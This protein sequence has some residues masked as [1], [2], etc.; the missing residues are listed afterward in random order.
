MIKKTDEIF[1]TLGSNEDQ[2]SFNLEVMIFDTDKRHFYIHHDVILPY[3]PLCCKWLNYRNNNDM[4]S[5]LL[6]VGGINESIEIFDIDVMDA[7]EPVCT[8]GGRNKPKDPIKAQKILNKYRMNPDF[9]LHSD[10]SPKLKNT[11]LGELKEGSHSDSIMCLDWHNGNNTNIISGSADNS[12]KI[13]DLNNKSCINTI[14]NHKDKVQDIAIHLI[15]PKVFISGSFD[16]TCI[17]SNINHINNKSDNKVFKLDGEVESLQWHPNNNRIFYVTLDN[18]YI[19]SYDVRNESKPLIS[20]KASKSNKPISCLSFN[21]SKNELFITGSIDGYIKIW[22]QNELNKMPQLLHEQKSQMGAVFSCNFAPKNMIPWICVFG[23]YE[24]ISILDIMS[25]NVVRKK[26]NLPTFD[27]VF[28]DVDITKH[29]FMEKKVDF[30]L[31]YKSNDDED[32]D[33][34]A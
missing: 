23:G 16:K 5:N 32:S 27:D 24:N 4:N 18:G 7:L 12:I 9:N 29:S 11:C 3:F 25:L 15:E 10:L 20:F 2:T 1:V 26:Y 13:W 21:N 22:Y 14:L 17:L 33:L 19:A 28:N 30:N 8:L 6:A 34:N 31:E